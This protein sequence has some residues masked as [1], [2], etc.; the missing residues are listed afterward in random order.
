MT[1]T[2]VKGEAATAR[3]AEREPAIFVERTPTP[4]GST[5]YI[6]SIRFSATSKETLEQK[7]LRLI[8]SEVR[9]LA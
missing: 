8:E 1:A 7:L 3:H 9:K 2:A 4:V 6:V 5:D